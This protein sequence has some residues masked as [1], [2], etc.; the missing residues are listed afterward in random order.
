MA[1]KR[2]AHYSKWRSIQ[3]VQGKRITGFGLSDR[4]G[5][6]SSASDNCKHGIWKFGKYGFKLY[7][8]SI[9]GSFSIVKLLQDD[10]LHPILGGNK[11]RKLDAVMPFLTAQSITDLVRLCRFCAWSREQRREQGSHSGMLNTS[12]LQATGLKQLARDCQCSSLC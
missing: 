9:Q 7:G 2:G 6:S 11:L 4:S 10:L 3:S 8:A 5:H 12:E 1:V